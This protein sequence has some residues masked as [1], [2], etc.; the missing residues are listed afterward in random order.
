MDNQYVNY[1]LLSSKVVVKDVPG[2]CEWPLVVALM[3]AEGG[4]HGT[5]ITRGDQLAFCSALSRRTLCLMFYLAQVR[6]RQSRQP[7]SVL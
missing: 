6:P 4:E 2:P 3:K 1:T 5:A 7:W